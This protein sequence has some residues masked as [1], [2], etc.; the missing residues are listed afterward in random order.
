VTFYTR[1]LSSRP[2]DH[3]DIDSSAEPVMCIGRI[4]R[5]PSDWWITPPHNPK[6]SIPDVNNPVMDSDKEA[7]TI[8]RNILDDQELIFCRRPLSRPN[9]ELWYTAMDAETDAR[10]RK[11]TWDVVVRPT[12]RKID[13]SKYIFKIIRH[14][15]RSI[16]IF[17]G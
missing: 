14:S 2:L 4:L 8:C 7:L 5:T 17:K 10:Q 16:D 12:D 11:H 15:N 9:T 1:T 3:I 6:T 13:D